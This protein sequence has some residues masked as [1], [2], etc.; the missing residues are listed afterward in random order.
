M[1][2]VVPAADGGSLV[3]LVSDSGRRTLH[4]RTDS[5]VL[6][7]GLDDVVDGESI[8]GFSAVIGYGDEP[9]D[10]PDPTADGI[11]SMAEDLAAAGGTARSARP[12]HPVTVEVL[13]PEEPGAPW[14]LY[15]DDLPAA[16][17]VEAGHEAEALALQLLAEHRPELVHLVEGDSYDTV[18]SAYVPDEATARAVA[19][20]LRGTGS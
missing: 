2:D 3:R 7:V 12:R 1:D 15:S 10:L 16:F 19:E 9:L 5:T 17:G 20:V 18:F 14:G 11:R 6:L 4:R 8:A 13:A